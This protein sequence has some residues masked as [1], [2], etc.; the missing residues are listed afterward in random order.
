MVQQ[1]NMGLRILAPY[2]DS[3]E[4]VTVRHGVLSVVTVRPLGATERR[5]LERIGWKREPEMSEV[6][7]LALR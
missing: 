6:W 7:R 3:D 2:T 5:V 4:A 1:A